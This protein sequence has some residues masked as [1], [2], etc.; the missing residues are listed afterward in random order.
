MIILIKRHFK[1]EFAKNVL[2]LVT[3]TTIAQLISILAAPALSRFYDP[4]DFSVFAL[5]TSTVAIISVIA[6]AR[7]ELAIPLEKKDDDAKSVLALSIL[8]SFIVSVCALIFVFLYHIYAIRNNIGQYIVWYYLIPLIVFSTGVYNAFNFWSTRMKTYKLNSY[9]RIALA[10]FTSITSVTFGYYHFG[11]KGL[12][13]GFFIGQIVA[14]IVISSP[15]WRGNKNLFQDVNFK[16]IK[17]QFKKHISFIKINSPHALLDSLQDNGVVYLMS[18]YFIPAV[19]GWYS[20]AFR[21]LKAPV[22]LIGS[23]FYQVFYQ[24][25]SHA[26]NEGSDLRPLVKNMFLRMFILG[27][28]G[29]A[30]L[31]FYS[32][33]LFSLLFGAKWYEAGVIASILTPW[34]FLNFIVSPVSSITLVCNKQFQGF[35]FTILDS[36]VRLF[37]L[38][39]GGLKNDYLLSFKIISF[40]CSSL[41]ITAIFWYYS[42]AVSNSNIDYGN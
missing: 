30:I 35:I 31:Y 42:I 18:Y 40:S 8:I 23:A 41:M 37:A 33:E 22:G 19:T 9:G 34:L 39:L 32:P 13:L 17:E 24:K 20:F 2:T 1:T 5:F 4:T 28:P 29:F 36:S 21:I 12:I 6:T 27:L 38:I 3:G 11:P 16:G 14:T 7:Y 25:L 10:V 15:Y 26:K